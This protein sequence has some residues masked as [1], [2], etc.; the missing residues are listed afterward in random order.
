MQIALTITAADREPIAADF[1]HSIRALNRAMVG[2]SI[3]DYL[4]LF[5]AR[6]IIQDIQIK[7]AEGE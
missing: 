7:V 4:A 3:N 5:D 2:A 6:A 1:D